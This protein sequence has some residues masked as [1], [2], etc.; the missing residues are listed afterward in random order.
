MSTTALPAEPYPIDPLRPLVDG[1]YVDQV[2]TVERADGFAGSPQTVRTGHFDLAPL[3][4]QRLLLRHTLDAATIDDD[5]AGLLQDELFAPGWLTGSD[6]FERLFTGVV[7]TSSASALPAWIAFY[8]NTLRRLEGFRA[9]GDTDDPS[10]SGG[11]LHAFAPVHARALR[12]V[13]TAPAGRTAEVLDVGSCFGFFP[14]QLAARGIGV[15]ASDV[16]PGTVRLLAT[17]APLVLE[18]GRSLRTLTCDAARVPLAARSVRTVTLLH[19]LEHVDPRH[20]SAILDE[21]RRLADTRVVVAVPLEEEATL[22]F[23]HVRTVS[24]DDLSALGDSTGWG[25]R[26][27]EDHGGWLVLDRP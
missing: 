27:D 10:A 23:G 1:R 12:E 16:N 21:A 2:V 5:L 9:T 11:S 18:P 3:P 8:R 26:V 7:L 24:L 25:F 6:T 20:A 17:V 13:A 4:G 14:L 19:L 22:A 15:T